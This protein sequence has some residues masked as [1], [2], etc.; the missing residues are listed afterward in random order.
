LPKPL[1]KC[2]DFVHIGE[3]WGTPVPMNAKPGAGIRIS[4]QL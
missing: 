2:R 1:F 4:R 3:C